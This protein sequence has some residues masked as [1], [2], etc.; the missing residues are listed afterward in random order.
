MK[1]DELVQWNDSYSV[2]FKK[3]D[4][5]HKELVRMTNELIT[6]CKKGNTKADASFMKTIQGAVNYAR[7]H[8]AT[9]EVYMEKVTYP[10][11]KLHKKEHEGFVEEV[12]RQ[13]KSFEDGT[14]EPIAFARFLK[15]WLLNHIAVSDKKYAPF[16]SNVKE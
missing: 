13:L 4:D 2:Q 1:D 3:I 5:Q 10:E 9:E 6:G 14:S 7:T 8:F 15:N 12:L 16:L 11:Y